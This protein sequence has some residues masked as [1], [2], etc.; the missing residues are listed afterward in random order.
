MKNILNIGLPTILTLVRL[1][2]SPLALPF[3]LVYLLPLHSLYLNSFLAGL[4]LAFGLTDFFDGYLARR[5]NQVTRI[6]RILDPIADKFLLYT[7]LIAL[8]TAHKIYF[9]WVVIFIGR[10][11]FVMGLRLVALEHGF[12]I[13]VSRLAKLKTVAQMGC[14]FFIILNPYQQLGFSDA[15]AWNSIEF[16]LL[17]LALALTC[18]SAYTYYVG[19]AQR[20]NAGD[21]WEHVSPTR[22]VGD[23]TS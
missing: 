21:A 2:V 7:V 4:F 19:F 3:L 22:K 18:C 1:V 11:F 23:H 17:V 6:G 9:F 14:L 15:L 16:A 10:E 5:F 20:F 12:S 13:P 8:L